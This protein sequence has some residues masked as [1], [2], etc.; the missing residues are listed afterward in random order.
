MYGIN[1]RHEHETATMWKE[2]NL[3]TREV[4]LC[5]KLHL[6]KSKHEKKDPKLTGVIR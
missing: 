1:F 5:D 2:K 3:E 4:H 6:M